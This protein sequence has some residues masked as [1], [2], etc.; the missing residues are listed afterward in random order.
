[1]MQGA[2]VAIENPDHRIFGLQYHPEV[3]HTEQGT[4]TLRHFLLDIAGGLVDDCSSIVYD[5]D[6][7]LCHD[8]L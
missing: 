6:Q 8:S 4:D 3:A 2:V 1:M 5:S 7:P